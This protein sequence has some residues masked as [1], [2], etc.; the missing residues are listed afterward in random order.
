[1]DVA[2][3][4][5]GES[6]A[7][8]SCSICG[9]RVCK[10]HLYREASTGRVLCVICKS[11]VCSVCG[12]RLSVTYCLSCGKMVCTECSVQ[13]DNVRRVCIECAR[14]GVKPKPAPKNLKGASRLTLKV[15]RLFAG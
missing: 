1:L 8:E 14:K 7:I 2:C 15:L 3:E 12:E 11:A 13:L 10:S 5:C 9:R 4:V 6:A